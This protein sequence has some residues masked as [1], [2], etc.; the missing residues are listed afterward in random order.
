MVNLDFC[1]NLIPLNADNLLK[2]SFD[3]KMIRIEWVRRKW[4]MCRAA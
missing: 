2:N 3:P 1:L 4:R